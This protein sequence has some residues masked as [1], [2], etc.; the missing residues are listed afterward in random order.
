[1]TKNF[2]ISFLSCT[3]TIW[4]SFK[5]IGNIKVIG[6]IA[7]KLRGQCTYNPS[8][9]LILID[10]FI[11]ITDTEDASETDMAKQSTEYTEIKEQ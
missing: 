2:N 5:Q 8:Q 11:F 10:L 7:L 4:I 3:L 1:M 9:L 6:N